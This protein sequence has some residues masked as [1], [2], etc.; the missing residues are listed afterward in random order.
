MF[1]EKN[2]CPKCG[3]SLYELE[4][5][6]FSFHNPAGAC[7][8]CNGKGEILTFDPDL[9]IPDRNKTLLEGAILPWKTMTP[10]HKRT[11]RRL[12]KHFGFD[13]ETPVKKF[14]AKQ[15]QVILYGSKEKIKDNIHGGK[16]DGVIGE[17]ERVYRK[18][19][20]EETIK[21]TEEL[22][23]KSICPSCKGKKLKKEILA[24]KINN[25]SI[26]DAGEMTLEDF[27][28][29]LNEL[30]LNADKKQ[31]ANSITEEI[32]T[33]VEN[34]IKID[35]DY[36][37]IDRKLNT[38][39]K[40]E[41][42]R[43]RLSS[44]I[45]S[46]LN[47]L[48]YVLDEPTQGLHVFDTHNL[49]KSLNKLKEKGNTLLIIDHNRDIINSSDLI[50]DMGPGAGKFGG[51]I[52]SM[53]SLDKIK[54]DKNSLTGHYLAKKE[55][56]PTPKKRKKPKHFL[57]LKNANAN[58]LKNITVEFPLGVFC[59]ITGVSGSG[60]SSLIN[61]SLLNWLHLKKAKEQSKKKGLRIEGMEHIKE[62]IFINQDPIG[63]SSRSNSAT[64]IGLFDELATLFA[65]LLDSKTQ[66]LQKDSFSFNCPKEWCEECKGKGEIKI[67]LGFMEPIF[68]KCP[69]C[70]GKRYSERILNI[71]Y[72]NKNINDILEMSADEAFDFFQ[73]DL[74]I[75]KYLEILKKVNLG[76]ITL[77]QKATTL[78]GGEAQR[79]KLAK[80]LIK[81]TQGKTLYLLDEPT[82]G[83]HFEDTKKLMQV[84]DLLVEQGNSVIALEHNLDVIKHA[85]Y[86][87][88]L[89]PFG[90]T[91]GG[92]LVAFGTPEQIARSPKSITGKFL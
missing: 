92:E 35:L 78:S 10:Y 36:L 12:G 40:G 31:I 9:I 26:I 48:T 11:L 28:K 7:P 27:L 44:Q 80:E 56:I 75:Q 83:L 91:R 89:G 57:I 50:V 6:D 84:L 76:Y 42:Q 20:S 72:K 5:Q 64:Y 71:H 3:F 13:I 81:G 60:K 8:E 24:V 22:M 66:K 34:L 52:V 86:V 41:I 69:K 79:I 43:L 59:V 77:G 16:F 4:I 88:D 73:E 19:K 17:L 21:Q 37:S 74:Q 23:V 82:T 46:G 62:V 33:K 38:L 70:N 67:E 14:N 65:K 53:G 87:I 1:S 25:A 29:F 68:T 47:D 2:N 45:E 39:S 58:N 30:K 55:I 90:G 18:T 85:D 54:K 15:M 49:I 61:D 32:K 51:E 63:R